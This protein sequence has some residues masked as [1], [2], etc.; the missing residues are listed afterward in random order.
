MPDRVELAARH[1]DTSMCHVKTIRVRFTVYG[2]GYGLRRGTARV[3]RVMTRYRYRSRLRVHLFCLLYPVSF[4]S[5]FCLPPQL[6]VCASDEPHDGARRLSPLLDRW[7]S[8]FSMF[9]LTPRS[10]VLGGSVIVALG[11]G[12]NYVRTPTHAYAEFS[13]F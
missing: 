13:E 5:P 7:S 4:L 6:G 1:C 2:Y 10:L 11:S 8:M 12:T 9:S 3:I